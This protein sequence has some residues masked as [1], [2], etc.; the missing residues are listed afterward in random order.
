MSDEMRAHEY[1]VNA[2]E[3]LWKIRSPLPDEVRRAIE[4][5]YL[6]GYDRGYDYGSKRERLVGNK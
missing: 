1:A 3:R 4:E 2:T 5:A 6:Q